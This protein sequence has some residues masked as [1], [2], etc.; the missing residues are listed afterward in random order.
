MGKRAQRKRDRNRASRTI[1]LSVVDCQK[2]RELVEA[3]ILAKQDFKLAYAEAELRVLKARR[4]QL[5]FVTTLGLRYGFDPKAPFEFNAQ[6]NELR[7]KPEGGG[8]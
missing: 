1:R 8:R 4:A 5:E 2:L 3:V 6:T 7:P